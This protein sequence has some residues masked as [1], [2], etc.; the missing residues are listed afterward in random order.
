M[1]AR[2]FLIIAMVPCDIGDEHAKDNVYQGLQNLRPWKWKPFAASCLTESVLVY[3]I[4]MLIT[5][6]HKNS[7]G[8]RIQVHWFFLLQLMYGL[9][10]KDP[11]MYQGSWYNLLCSPASLCP[12]LFINMSNMTQKS[13][14]QLESILRPYSLMTP[15]TNTLIFFL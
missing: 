1:M 8:M 2:F 5:R 15:A 7:K 9:S 3:V 6:R 14:F 4:V 11:P 13:L 12:S 10:L